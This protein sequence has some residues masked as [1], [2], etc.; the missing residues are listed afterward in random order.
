MQLRFDSGHTSQT[1]VSAQAWR[2]ASLACCPLHPKGGCGLTRHGTYAR[3]HPPGTR[4]ARWRCARARRTFSLLPNHLAA[5]F[6]GTL[7]ELET[8]VATVE[9]SSSVEAAANALRPDCISLASAVRWV[10]RRVRLVRGNL[11]VVMSLLP[12]LFL[13]CAPRVEAL[14]AWL[15]VPAVLPALRAIAADHLGNLSP[16]LGFRPPQDPGGGRHARF[17][18][19]MGPDPPGTGA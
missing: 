9:R 2:E 16:P 3:K 4:I 8:V 18:H 6:P 11:N 19:D 13:N 5:R 14:S 7:I 1:Y 10:R 12:A 15:G 17:Q